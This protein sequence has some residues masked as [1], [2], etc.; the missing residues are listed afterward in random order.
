MLIQTKEIQRIVTDE[1][2]FR[3]GRILDI[4]SYIE[5]MTVSYDE[6]AHFYRVI[7][8]L[9]DL[10]MDDTFVLSL[11]I[12]EEGLVLEHQCS[13]S[14]KYPCRHIVAILLLLKKLNIQ[15]Y[16]Y[17]YE[18]DADIKQSQNLEMIEKKRQERILNKKFHESN[19]LMNL[20]KNQLVVESKI[21]LSTQ[22][23]QLK[24]FVKALKESLSMTVKIVYN[25]QSFV[26]R[27]IETFLHAI[28]YH[29][30][31][32]Y[33]K[34]FE[35]AHSESVFDED[36][37]EILSFIRECYLKNKW[38]QKGI[39][40]DLIVEGEQLDVFFNLMYSLPS[41][42]SDIAYDLIKQPIALD[43]QEKDDSFLID[44][45]DYKE[46]NH[47]IYTP[48]YMYD[49]Q[50]DI[51]YRYDF[52]ESRKVLLFIQKLK[53][54]DDGLYVKKE[55]IIDFYKYV[56]LDLKEDITFD[57]HYFNEY[58]QENRINLYVDMT[59]K[60]QL[61]IQLEYI[62]DDE[63]HYGFEE[64]PHKSKEADI[65]ESYLEKYI[66]DY[67]NNIHYLKYSHDETFAFLHEGLQYLS[68]YCHV[69][70]SE[71]LKAMSQK[72]PTSFKVGVSVKNG[73]LEVNVESIDIAKDELYDVLKAYKKNR[74]FYKL[75]NGEVIQLDTQN[76]KE[77]DTFASELQL[78]YKELSQDTVSLP[79]YRIMEL[80]D[81]D[82]QLQT[83]QYN[84][85]DEFNE[86]LGSLKE[87]KETFEIPQH[88]Q[89]ILRGY[90]KT[91]FEWLS[92]MHHYGFGGI[93]ADD[94]GLGKTLQMIAYLESVKGKHIVITPASLLLNWQDE[95]EK[96]SSH[97][98]TLC[99]LG[100]KAKRESLIKTITDDMIVITS[101][102]YIRRDIDSYK[103]IV[104]DTV[105]LDE[106]Q[107]IKNPK[108]KNAQSVKRL[109]AKQRFALTGTPIE[110][111]LAELWSIFDFL[112]PGYLYNYHRFVDLFEKPIVKDKDEEKQAKLKHMISPFVLRRNK[113]EVLTE[114]PDKIEQTLYMTFSE[115]EEK[116]YL[117]N[118]IQ[119]NKSLQE[120]YDLNQLGKIDIL[121]MLTRL[122]QICQ[123]PRLV[124]DDIKEPSSKIKGC[125]E[126][127]HTL[128]NNKKKVLLFSSFTS[129]LSLLEEQCKK[130]HIS[131]FRLDGSVSKDKRKK[132]VDTFQKDE[133]TLFLISLKAGGTGLNLTSAQ[134][135]I[136]FDPWWNMS[137][138]N[139]ATDRTHRIG[140]KESV[141][142]F[143]LI[144]KDSI[145]EKIQKLQ[146]DKKDLSD[147]FVEGNE[148]SLSKLSIEDMRELF[149]EN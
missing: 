63:I 126:L 49:Y 19:E 120:K 17:F 5:R 25:N 86:W 51:L 87:P 64:N 42:Y 105:V 58:H 61:F 82:H 28:D 12:N 92:L 66:D 94:M 36:S 121:A 134:A 107:Y 149:I 56:L 141:Q 14:I 123:D 29:E 103:D 8:R 143:S 52:D 111:S 129:V 79:I 88:Y 68:H 116:M 31:L 4:K 44:F 22:K 98:E 47:A 53:E 81:I 136:H 93:L 118:L 95:I 7:A 127:I 21:P 55:H 102:D 1:K 54:T 10:N 18:K 130:E 6:S 40:K 119:V 24:V 9:H 146:E 89:S 125:M 145:E 114:L 39:I 99:I 117:A 46:I 76:F 78:S 101:Y 32:K 90:Q 13:C 113:K 50:D 83:I 35:F 27:N 122:R 97:L 75:K 142:V 37:S 85:T 72:E 132:L 135:V 2:E 104:F 144:M 67:D 65:V 71:A 115:E 34:N 70:I 137:A 100:T 74:K 131:Y 38:Q 60:E 91:G 133:T 20:Y 33:G 73:L 139:Q 128:K 30:V 69:F 43:I 110:N 11:K 45:D 80:D 96:F 138:K 41:F 59:T 140:Q 23:Y 57:D 147:A 77:L 109:N 48:Q 84:K 148:T 26:I 124:D 15:A 3:F 106:A 62:Y 108:T 16:P 112:M